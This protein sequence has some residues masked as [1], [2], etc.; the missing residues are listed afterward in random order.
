MVDA[1]IMFFSA[2]MIGLSDTYA[3][4]Q[5]ALSTSF[6]DSNMFVCGRLTTKA[7]QDVSLECEP[8]SVFRYLYVYV[9]ATNQVALREVAVYGK[10]CS[11]W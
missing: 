7:G 2:Y 4:G 11:T 3:T 5:S 8:D 10:L 9:G 6:V 1:S